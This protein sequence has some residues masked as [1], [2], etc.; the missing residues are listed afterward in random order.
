MKGWQLESF[1]G[2]GAL[3]LNHEVKIPKITTPN[4]ILVKVEASS[5]NPLDVMMTKGYGKT[6]LAN[7]RSEESL[8]L[9]R[10]FSGTVVDTGMSVK[11]Y[12]IGDQV[13]GATFPSSQGSHADF[14]TASTLTLS[15]KPF[16][17]THVQAASIPFTSLTAWSSMMISAGMSLETSNE[18]P[19]YKVLLIGASGGVGT[20]AVQLLKA[21]N[22]SVVAVSKDFELIA[23]FGADVVLDH[24]DPEYMK[25]LKQL[26]SFDVIFDF[27][28]LG[29]NSLKYSQ[30]LRPWS[31][32]KIV[33]LMSPLL[34]ST[35]Q[36]GLVPG[37]IQT[38]I[39]LAVKNAQTI[40]N[41][42]TF[43]Y[44]YFMPNPQAL[45][46]IA[47]LIEKGKIKSVIQEEFKLEHLPAAYE[48]VEKGN[49][50]GK[51]V[52]NHVNSGDQVD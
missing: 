46:R 28:G 47:S 33:T 29:E 38:A 41:G 20:F 21:L 9:G 48:M 3:V 31:N 6:V 37:A 25:Q 26:S 24:E 16:N 32:S 11:D 17:M 19:R 44:G 13:Y 18:N 35:D 23:D 40:N 14:V 36:N 34:R 52:V 43:R 51:V 1:S 12:K 4:D 8:I 49:L 22:Y 30:F 10:D 2:I 39:E 42:V 27:A 5:V 15:H 45:K 7:L 50:R